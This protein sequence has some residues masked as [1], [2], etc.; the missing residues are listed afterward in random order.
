M[1]TER[2]E[3]AGYFNRVIANYTTV[4]N[5][6][7]KPKMILLPIDRQEIMRVQTLDQNPGW[8]Q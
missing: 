2:T 3:R 1:D 5:R 7:F 4:R 6:T 8:E